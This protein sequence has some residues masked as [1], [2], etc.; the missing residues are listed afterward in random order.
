[1]GQLYPSL[2]TG[3]FLIIDNYGFYQGA[4]KATDMYIAENNLDIFLS[5]IHWFVRMGVKTS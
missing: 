3:G 2:S 4:C 5:R 1:M